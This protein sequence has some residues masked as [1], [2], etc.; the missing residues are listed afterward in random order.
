MAAGPEITV[1]V[2]VYNFVDGVERLVTGLAGQ[3]LDPGRFEVLIIDNCSTDGTGEALRQQ[4]ANGPLRFELLRTTV[5]GGGPAGARNLGWRTAR[6]PIVAFID[7][8]ARPDSK[9][10]EAGLAVMQANPR[11]GVMQGCTLPPP[12][13]ALEK[14]DR[15]HVWRHIEHATPW[16]EGVNVFYRKAALDEVPEGFS[17]EIGFWGED[18]KLAWDVIAAGWD[19]DFCG[20]AV[21]VHDV[22]RRGWSW[23][24][25]IAWSDGNLVTIAAEH[26][27]FRAEGFWRSW[28]VRREDPA[29]VLAAAGLVG[30][31]RWKPALALTLPYLWW[32][33]PSHHSSKL[34]GQGLKIVATDA[35]RVASHLRASVEART[36]VL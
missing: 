16:F 11:L 27:Q 6:A 17:E 1:V 19:R 25:R 32:Q 3:T 8:D 28:A 7:D 21:V 36:F 18:I 9:W 33:R 23:W 2:P 13:V 35:I 26:P 5:N 34:V 20:D 10:L 31:L 29:L 15:W 4:Q 30:A 14:L 22:E 24:R 12:E